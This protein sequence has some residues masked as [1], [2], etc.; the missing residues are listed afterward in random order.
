MELELQKSK[1]EV[2][3]MKSIIILPELKP[4]TSKSE[5]ISRRKE[6]ASSNVKDKK[7]IFKL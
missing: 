3:K 4:V 1:C 2:E 6:L 5:E 7:L